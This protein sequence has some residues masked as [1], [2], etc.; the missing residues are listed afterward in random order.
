MFGKEL[1]KIRNP[2]HNRILAS[3]QHIVF[4]EIVHIPGSINTLADCLS[5]LTTHVRLEGEE[6]MMVKPRILGLSSCRARLAKQLDTEDPLVQNLA[7]VASL[8]EDYLEIMRLVEKQVHPKHLPLDCELKKVEGALEEIRVVT[9][10]NGDRI[11]CKDSAVYIPA[12][13]RSHMV[14]TL[15]LT[16]ASAESMLMNA[17]DRVWWPGIRASLHSKYNS[18][19]ECSL[20]RI[21]QQRPTNEVSQKG[22]V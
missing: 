5:R 15:H 19:K 9:M 20:F 21:S 13:E 16:H 18:C 1:T 8:D 11:M 12:S 22:L 7:G 6:M 14:D 17:K 10:T 2:K 3:I 4:R